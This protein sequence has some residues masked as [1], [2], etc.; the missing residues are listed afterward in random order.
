MISTQLHILD[1][2]I[3]LTNS[4]IAEQ[5]RILDKALIQR[6]A[7]QFFKSD[8]EDLRARL[9]AAGEPLPGEN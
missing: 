8:L 6:D 5:S 2:Y 9:I 1:N 3:G 7:L 4:R